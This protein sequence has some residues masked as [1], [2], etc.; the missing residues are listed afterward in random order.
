SPVQ[1]ERLEVVRQSSEALL[2]ILNDVLDLSK[3]EAGRFE[4]ED[5]EFDLAE[6]MKGA[7]SAF[8]ALANKKGLSF[9]LTVE[10]AARGVYR[11]DPTRVRQILYNLISNA[12][13]FT[14]HGEVR[15]TASRAGEILALTVADTGVGIAADRLDALFE[16]FTQADA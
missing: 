14:D 16:K 3:I 13:K 8:T 9:G 6:L 7:H 12:L 15:V 4:L 1:R 10:E 5:I 2:A 11:G